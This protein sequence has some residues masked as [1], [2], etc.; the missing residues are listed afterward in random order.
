MIAIQKK[1]FKKHTKFETKINRK[2]SWHFSDEINLFDIQ[3]TIIVQEF[4]NK[5]LDSVVAKKKT[6]IKKTTGMQILKLLSLFG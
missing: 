1:N 5:T 6:I 2:I 3:K 4:I